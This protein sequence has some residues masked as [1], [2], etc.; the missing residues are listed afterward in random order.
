[1]VDTPRGRREAWVACV[2]SG[3]RLRK[4]IPR[5]VPLSEPEASASSPRKPLIRSEVVGSEKVTP[6]DGPHEGG[7]ERTEFVAWLKKLIGIDDNRTFE[8][9][10]WR[11]SG[12]KS[13]SCTPK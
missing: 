13:K 4:A 11:R 10:N 7:D 2:A 1:M 3:G 9:K 6:H 12:M 8:P 5:F